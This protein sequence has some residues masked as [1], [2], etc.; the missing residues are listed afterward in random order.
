[1][2]KT[3]VKL[4]IEVNEPNGYHHL[5]EQVTLDKEVGLE[6]NLEELVRDVIRYRGAFFN[7]VL[8]EEAYQGW[9]RF[10]ISISPPL[11]ESGHAIELNGGE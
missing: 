11:D 7:E 8:G 4:L 5:E 1:M 9:R 6:G 3:Q 10:T 2:E